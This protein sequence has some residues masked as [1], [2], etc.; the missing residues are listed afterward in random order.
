MGCWR[1]GRAVGGQAGPEEGGAG[2]G[3]A[4]AADLAGLG[5]DPPAADLVIGGEEME[6]VV[7]GAIIR[8]GC[9]S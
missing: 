7:H 8:R 3:Q 9:D 2:L 5:V 4:A 1:A 6:L